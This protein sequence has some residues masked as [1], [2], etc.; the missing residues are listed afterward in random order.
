MWRVFPGL[1]ACP[2]TVTPSLILVFH[3]AAAEAILRTSPWSQKFNREKK[4]NANKT[5]LTN[6]DC[7][8]KMILSW[9]ITELNQT[10]R[11]LESQPS[12]Q[13]KRLA[14]SVCCFPAFPASRVSWCPSGESSAVKLAIKH[15]W[16]DVWL[17]WRLTTRPE[18][19]NIGQLVLLITFWHTA[20]LGCFW[21]QKIL[22]L[23]KTTTI[24]FSP[25][26]LHTP[27]F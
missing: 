8:Y 21:V 24:P 16:T 18:F 4:T 3:G 12:S 17:N 9:P 26:F 25:T 11:F 27:T 1:H 22:W 15:C 19:H 23:K 7:I 14:I 20:T 6:I 10:T 2:G 13:N 5:Y